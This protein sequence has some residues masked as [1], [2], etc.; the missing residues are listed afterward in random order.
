MTNISTFF[1]SMKRLSEVVPTMPLSTVPS[2]AAIGPEDD[3]LQRS[4]LIHAVEDAVLKW[5][6]GAN[7]PTLGELAAAGPI[8]LGAIFTHLGPFYGRKI[9]EATTRYWENKPIIDKPILWTKLDS[10]VPGATLTAQVHPQNY[11]VYVRTRRDG[12]EK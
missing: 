6:S 8:P 12:G 3:G 4:A 10:F 1:L 7:L 11:Y 5:L 2:V 9:G